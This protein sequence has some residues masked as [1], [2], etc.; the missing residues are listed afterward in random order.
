VLEFGLI[1]L[2]LAANDMTIQEVENALRNENI[3]LPA[4]TL[5]A[6]NIDLTINLDKSYNNI[7][8]LKFLPY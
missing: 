8:E 6:E 4:G 1:L 7:D 2:S 5:E 3:S